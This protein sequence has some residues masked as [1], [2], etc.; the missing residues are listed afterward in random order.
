MITLAAAVPFVRPTDC[1]HN[2]SRLVALARKASEAGTDVTLFPQLCI[3]GA[4]CGDLAAMP[5]LL[6]EAERQLNIFLEQ[7]ASLA[8]TF[9][10]SLPCRDVTD[11]S[12]TS[13]GVTPLTVA[14]SGGNVIARTLGNTPL[15]LYD[16]VVLQPAATPDVAGHY[17][18]LRRAL[19]ARSETE[20]K[21]II[22]CNS[23]FGESTTDHVFGGGALIV[24]NG[25]QLGEAQRFSFDEQL[26]TATVDLPS[27]SVATRQDE[28]QSDSALAVPSVNSSSV[29]AQTISPTPFLPDDQPADDYFEE[30]LDMQATALATRLTHIHCQKVILGISG[31]L[32][33]T[34]ALLASVRTFDR[35]GYDRTGIYGI[36]MPGFGTS[37]RTYHNALALMQHLGITMQE[38]PIRNAC[39][40]HFSD[41]GL[42]PSA[43]DV[44]YENSQA[45][46]R[47]QILM[48]LANK[49]G[50]IVVGTGDLSEIALGWCT[51]GGD[52]LSMYGVNGSIP[53][54]LMQHIVRHI[55][56]TTTDEVIRATLLD[57]VDTPISPELVP[58]GAP[59]TDSSTPTVITQ[60]TESIVGPYELHDFFLWHFLINRATPRNI[61]LTARSV[62]GGPDGKYT[63]EELKHWL[64]TFFRRFF[65]QQFKR[66]CMPDGPKITDISLSPRGA[67]SMPSDI[68]AT[69]WL[70]ECDAL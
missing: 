11:G 8:G 21:A 25:Q 7:T 26:I 20:H 38:I 52:H 62:F 43:R 53:K 27:S 31:G 39:M 70:N 65:S 67:W 23:G 35:L 49:V 30:I 24:S 5:T 2:V 22:Y 15:K 55:A 66:S 40:Q 28:D 58:A 33:S 42:D 45:R 50:A 46:E 44:T 6:N 48:D 37:D 61:Y 3:S 68:A 47:T 4:T 9:V 63:D 12:S 14:V 19:I 54:T 1:A 32:D 29:A 60:K 41:I 59:A 34:L 57:I 13:S 51:F 10:V 69:L 17:V 16:D 18:R 64:R 56:H 36:T